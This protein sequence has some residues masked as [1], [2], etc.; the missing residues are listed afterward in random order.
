MNVLLISQCTKRA[1]TET[2]RILDQFAERRG[3]RTWQ[4]AITE[5]GLNTLRRLLKKTAR[6]NTAVACHWIRGIDH[7]E[8]IWIVG[9]ARR[10]NSHGAVPTNT[11]ATD[12]LRNSREN[13]WHRAEDIRLL[14]MMSAL[15]HDIGKANSAFQRKLTSRKALADAYRHEW[16]SLRLF[17][18]FVGS[19]PDEVWLRRLADVRGGSADWLERLTCDGITPRA[20]SPFAKGRLP[21]LARVIGWLILTHHR[22]P[23]PQ[24]VCNRTMLEYL[25]DCILVDWNSPRT[26]A[27]RE[28]KADCW[29][30]DKGLPFASTEWCARASACARE[31]LSRSELIA[32]AREFIRDPYV[33]HLSRMVLMLADH[34]YSSQGSS[35]K[36]GDPN[37]GLYAN[38]DRKTGQLK[39]RLDEHL[40]GV[41]S[42][43]RR[44]ARTLPRLERDLPRIARHQGFKRRATREEFRWQNK[45]FDLAT[46]VQRRSAQSGFFGINM[47]ST[48]TGKT[49]ANGRILYG[50]AD[51]NRGARFTIAL[52]LRT[53][54]LQTGNVYRQRMNLGDDDMAVLVGG[55]A[56]RE[57]A[58]AIRVDAA[59]DASGSESAADLLLDNTFVH[60]ESSLDDGPLRRWLAAHSSANKLVSAP[61]LVCTVDHLV[62][63]TEGTR[64]GQQIAPMLRLLTSDL[65]LDEVDDFAL[66]DLPAIS[67]LI[68]WAGVLGA[69]VL[70]S[71]AT[72]PPALVSGLFDAYRA[73]RAIFRRHREGPAVD[74]VCCAWFDEFTCE[75]SS[76]GTLDSFSSAHAE[77]VRRRINH[78]RTETPRRRARITPVPVDV[79]PISELPAALARSLSHGIIELH[80]QHHL[81]DPSTSKRTSIGLIRFANIEPLIEVARQ[82]IFHGA[83]A[84]TRLH[85]CIYHSHHPLLMR[86]RIEQRLD[87]LLKRHAGRGAPRDP[88]LDQWEV[89]LALENER[90]QDQIFI[91]LASPVAE[92]GRDHDYDWA[93]VEPSSMR[94]IIQLAGRVRRHRQGE[95]RTPNVYLMETNIKGLK[96][97][98]I[99]FQRPGFEAADYRLESHRLSEILDR[100]QLE[101]LDAVPRIAERLSLEPAKNLVDL[102]HRRL[103]ALMLAEGE[104]LAIDAWWRTAAHLTS[105]LQM[106]QKFRRGGDE[107][108][109]ALLPNDDGEAFSLHRFYDGEWGPPL[110]NLVEQVSLDAGPRISFWGAT[111]YLSALQELAEL[112]DLDLDVCAKRFGIVELRESEQGWTYHP[113][114]GFGRRY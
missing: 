18:A 102:E 39:Q 8:L 30:F 7:S 13:D 58:G 80:D 64:G 97:E 99:A 33:M 25:P 40:I 22:L 70:L 60:Y 91:V 27:S 48:G 88:F 110:G 67:R 21:P 72:L 103:R 92:V 106:Q 37:F 6:K 45:A 98:K 77:F 75:A 66:E 105:C 14:A 26:D 79:K 9:D 16:V 36:Y 100:S 49:L 29:R 44:L 94:S 53:L 46:S 35:K 108:T 61:V 51:P 55:S 50:L 2:R 114:L 47:A 73:G 5:E 62:P 93:I 69:R 74:Q 31:I 10:F 112:F 57:L 11:T 23:A 52:G 87:T 78:L 42:H 113:Y 83:P 85:L 89:R 71:S 101:P 3:E 111:E 28:E 95:V 96:G 65:V 20:A 84:S 86:S 41:A 81:V 24:G 76:H 82:L 38:T 12:V 90:E 56:A 19:D 107:T 1:L 109:F 54:T 63:A 4:T 32:N 43:A 17:E 104:S 34:H 59:L 68:H 15:F